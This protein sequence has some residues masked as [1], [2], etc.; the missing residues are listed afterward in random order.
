MTK[1]ARLTFHGGVGSVTG[2]NFLLETEAGKM[3]IDCGM[4]QGRRMCNDEN[5]QDFKY[6]PT[7]IDVLLVTHAHIDHIGRIAKLVKDGF[8]GV[9]YSTPETRALAEVMLPDATRLAAEEAIACNTKPLYEEKDV[10]RA[11][12]LWQTHPYYEP[13]SVLD[14]TVTF[15]DAGHILG[16][17]FIECVHPVSGKIVFSGDLGNS[18]TLL[19]RDTDVVE[20]AD[21]MVIESVYGDRVHEVA[22]DR[23]HVLEDAIEDAANKG[24]TVL[25]P[26][27]SI[28]RT[29]LVLYE[30]N[31]LVENHSI[32]KIPV[33]LDSPLAIKVTDIYRNAIKHFNDETKKQIADGDDIFAF[34]NLTFVTS[35]RDSQALVDVK[36]PKIIIAGSGMSHG[37]RII[38]HEK[39]YLSDPKSTVLIVGYQSPGS[40]GRQLQD[41][42]SEVRIGN[43]HVAVKARIQTI[44]GFSGH[45][46]VDGLLGFIAPTAKTL[47]KLFVTMG[48]PKSSEFLAQRARD[49]LGVDATVPSL[50]DSVELL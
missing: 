8:T 27:F 20:D 26:A 29:Q 32:P 5:Y 38:H 12:E 13:L 6:D 43:E 16:S 18:P 25:I 10:Q 46:D 4:I 3:L 7:E 45:R 19:L 36:G 34:D 40:L 42:A 33:Y 39:I 9:I 47:K 41:G 21:Y 15:H 35:A 22:E 31:N 28:E 11:F 23:N 44:S 1:P 37:G 49:Y 14:C 30:I 17:A 24:G 50:G 48:E 2:A